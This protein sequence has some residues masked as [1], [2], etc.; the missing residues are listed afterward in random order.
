MMILFTI[1]LLPYYVPLNDCSTFNL[2]HFLSSL[3][4]ILVNVVS[5]QKIDKSVSELLVFI[6]FDNFYAS[7]IVE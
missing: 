5:F 6:V 3:I 1:L 7:F 2:I 4:L